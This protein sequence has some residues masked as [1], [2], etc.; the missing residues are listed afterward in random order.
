[1]NPVW[2]NTSHIWRPLSDVVKLCLLPGEQFLSLWSVLKCAV[3]TP[4]QDASQ[5]VTRKLPC[6]PFFGRNKP[7][8]SECPTDK[9]SYVQLKRPKI[10]P[11]LSTCLLRGIP[12][13]TKPGKGPGWLKRKDGLV[14]PGRQMQIRV[15]LW[16]SFQFA[17]V[18]RCKRCKGVRSISR[19]A[20]G[21]ENFLLTLFLLFPMAHLHT[22]TATRSERISVKASDSLHSPVV[23]FT[24]ACF[25]K[26]SNK[27]VQFS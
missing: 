16:V 3:L 15:L 21:K 25:L 10:W 17:E 1:M 8:I 22:K 2:Y 18:S 7:K 13:F 9:Y 14:S 24:A 6:Q 23:H 4:P 27:L 12:L 19:L 5:L 26:Q 20:W 11:A